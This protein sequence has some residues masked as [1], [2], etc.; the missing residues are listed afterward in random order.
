MLAG[1]FAGNT[2]SDKTGDQQSPGREDPFERPEKHN[3]RPLKVTG[4]LVTH[5]DDTHTLSSPT[6]TRLRHYLGRISF[7]LGN[8]LVSFFFSTLRTN[9]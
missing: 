7:V 9:R 8:T 5:Q 6:S 1:N 3:E 4:F 2:R